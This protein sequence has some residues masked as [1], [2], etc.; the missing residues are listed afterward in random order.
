MAVNRPPW[1]SLAE[2]CTDTGTPKTGIQS[3]YAEPDVPLGILCP[4]T[5]PME[6]VPSLRCDQRLE[7]C[8]CRPVLQSLCQPC[9]VIDSVMPAILLPMAWS[10]LMECRCD[11]EL[12]DIKIIS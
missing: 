3:S 2:L 5:N 11:Y 7:A 12:L 10:I 8:V 1:H 6:P 9:K 4:G